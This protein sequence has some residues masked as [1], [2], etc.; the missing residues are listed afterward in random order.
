MISGK[1]VLTGLMAVIQNPRFA[2]LVIIGLGFFLRIS[3]IDFGLPHRYHV[4]EPAHVVTAM[5]IG[6]GDLLPE[7][8]PNSPHLW[9]VIL[10]FE[11]GLYFLF[12]RMA[13]AFGSPLDLALSYQN[14]PTIFYLM[15][16][17]TSAVLGTLT[18]GLVYLIGLKV[19]GRRVGLVASLFFS[20]C[21]L[22]VRDS[23]FAVPDAFAVFLITMSAFFAIRYLKARSVKNLIFA[24]VLG[25]V[26]T[27]I[28]SFLP[29]F[30]VFPLGLTPWIATTRLRPS[31]SLLKMW[32]ITGVVFLVFVG[33]G[34]PGLVARLVFRPGGVAT[35]LDLA[36]MF[37]TA[38]FQ[39]FQIDPLPAWLFYLRS[40][41]WG[42]GLP[43]ALMSGVGM[44]MATLRCSTDNLVL[45]SFPIMHYLGISVLWV[46]QVRY[47][48]PLFPFLAIFAAF[49]VSTVFD[50]VGKRLMIS[51]FSVFAIIIF[52]LLLA[53]AYYS[54]QLDRLFQQTDTRTLAKEWVE[55]NIPAGA[56]IAVQWHT[57]ILA[58][59]TNPEPNSSRVYDV[60]T[61]DPF[62]SDARFYSL[63]H[64]RENGF[65]YLVISSYIYNL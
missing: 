24:V 33:I 63:D 30:I 13:G 41:V 35:S 51:H 38:E 42:W 55:R 32:V 6:S 46:P 28:K 16:R 40:F 15:P 43:L 12:G 17:I 2:L 26:A 20:F 23:H 25:G 50:W 62:S 52:L 57:P 11:Y 54:I 9:H 27:G 49:A 3:G 37:L 18:I 1:S 4:D 47:A 58:T 21:L 31:V 14:D 59:P 7:Y 39:G 5:K 56:K 19:H 53:P 44:W 36:H 10:L 60:T 34:I 22:H 64:Y 8:P 61:I 29:S 45:L 48:L 65:Q